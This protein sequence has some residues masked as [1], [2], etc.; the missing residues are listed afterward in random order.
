MCPESL[1]SICFSKCHE[2]SLCGVV[3]GYLNK[4]LS[5]DRTTITTH[6]L[7]MIIVM[8][9]TGLTEYMWCSLA[10]GLLC[11]RVLIYLYKY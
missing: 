8:S 10:V 5:K 1:E 6:I 9:M 7:R 3:D 2:Y 4:I 11:M